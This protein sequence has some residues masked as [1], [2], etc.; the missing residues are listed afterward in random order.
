MRDIGRDEKDIKLDCYR[1]ECEDV[2]WIQLYMNRVIHYTTSYDDL[3]NTGLQKS[4]KKIRDIN[5][6]DKETY[7]PHYVPVVSHNMSTNFMLQIKETACRY[8]S[9]LEH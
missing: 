3:G 9:E 2:T 4:R 1:R 5:I 8:N 6:L 7:N